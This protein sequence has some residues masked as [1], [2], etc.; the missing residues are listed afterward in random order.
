[1]K[2]L[3]FLSVLLSLIFIAGCQEQ[4]QPDERLET[5]V[6]L[7]NDQEYEK[8]YSDYLTQS[9]KETYSTEDFKDRAQ[10]IYQDFD[11]KNFE[12]TYQ[13]PEEEQEWEDQESAKF[14]VVIKMTTLAGDIE[15]E[16]EVELI[17]ESK[18]DQENWFLNWTPELILPNLEQNDK[19]RIQTVPANRGEIYDRNDRALAI[20][21]QAYEIGVVPE[22]FELA[23]TGKA[24]ELLDITPEFIEEQM[25]QSWVQPEHFVPLKKIPMSNRELAVELTSIEGV[26][27]QKVEAREYPYVEAL[28]HL[29]GH[30]GN[31]TAEEYEELKG[32]GYS[33]QA[34]I[35][36]RGLEELYEEK[37]RG[38]DGKVIYIEKEN[39]AVVDVASSEVMHGE[40]ITLTIDAEVQ[41]GLYEQMKDEAGTAAAVNPNTGE[42][43]SLVSVPSFDPIQ[44]AL[45]ISS[46]DYKALQ[47]NPDNPLTNRIVN[48]YSPGSTMKGITAAIGLNSGKLD[49]SKAYTIEGKQWQKDKSWGG[50]KVTR[51]FDNDTNVDL[52]SALKY[53]DNIYFARAGLDMGADS[54]QQGLKNFG[55]GEEVP[56]EYPITSSQI[57][58]D[59]AIS[60]EI[61]LADSA[62]GQGQILMSV[63][64]LANSYGAIIN[65]GIMMKPLLINGAKEEVWKNDLLSKENAELLK[66]DLR[67]VVTEGIAGKAA[68]EGKAI[69]GK[70]GT[71][72]IKSEQGTTG[73]ENGLF[74]S[75]DQNNPEFVLAM[76]L[77]NVEESGG[78]THTVEV[79]K[80][81][82]E[83]W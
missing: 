45:G 48:A 40:K 18:D 76:L 53:S 2:K 24:A 10:K 72:E 73:S 44:F 9:T 78:S 83:S 30:T 74:V 67:K 5:Y 7:W 54:F 47:D 59:G 36:K 57:A 27:N 49:P 63:L 62:Y 11:V 16:K 33:E 6:K 71:A 29:V 37:L 70:T 82:Y 20:N 52:E 64:H 21:G 4:P 34:V 22:K 26:F 14:P 23:N 56:F 8:M 51:V 50:Y 35:G 12:V 77:E 46:K 68:V 69:A 55:Y 32:K 25:N 61:L 13:K 60:E 15:Y 81:F 42:V 43:L 65:D 66:T 39:G 17:K 31:I 38:Q 3:V 58:N 80:R 75:Y 41:K 79:T 28:A 1:M 19:V